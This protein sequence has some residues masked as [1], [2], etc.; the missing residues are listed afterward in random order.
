MLKY[1]KQ[2]VGSSQSL[3]SLILALKD[4]HVYNSPDALV[5]SLGDRYA[6]SHELRRKSKQNASYVRITNSAERRDVT[7]MSGCP[8]W[9]LSANLVQANDASGQKNK[10][11]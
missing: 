4:H 9:R 8:D 3:L 2:T 10:L 7:R 6:P 1:A 5:R 11:P